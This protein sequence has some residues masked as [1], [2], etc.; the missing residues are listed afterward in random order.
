VINKPLKH[1]LRQIM[2]IVFFHEMKPIC[3][4]YDLEAPLA[5]PEKL[6]VL[7]F[8]ILPICNKYAPTHKICVLTLD[9]QPICANYGLK[10]D[11]RKWK[12]SLFG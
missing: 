5:L 6:S 4:E 12:N 7:E 10:H 9:I 3:V 11:L 2:N 8:D 1:E